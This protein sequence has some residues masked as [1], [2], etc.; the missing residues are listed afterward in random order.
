MGILPYYS[1]VF[2]GPIII[3]HSIAMSIRRLIPFLVTT[4]SLSL[5]VGVPKQPIF[6]TTIVNQESFRERSRSY[7]P[8]F[9]TQSPPGEVRLNPRD[10]YLGLQ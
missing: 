2:S 4:V 7:F 9:T 5:H 8:F 3:I 6:G 1:V 10:R